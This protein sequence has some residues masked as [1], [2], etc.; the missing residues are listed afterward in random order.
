MV[1]SMLLELVDF[2]VRQAM[3]ATG[4]AVFQIE[5]MRCGVTQ[6]IF[7]TQTMNHAL[8][9]L[10]DRLRHDLEGAAVRQDAHDDFLTFPQEE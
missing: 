4:P 1:L 9:S 5:S 2:L 7:R 8:A 3:Q 6:I 10:L